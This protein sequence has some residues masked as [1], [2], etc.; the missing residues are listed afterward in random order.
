MAQHRRG[1]VDPSWQRTTR[2][3][4]WACSSPQ[5]PAT[6]F[7]APQPSSATVEATAWGDGADWLLEQVPRLLGA[8]DD[9]PVE[10]ASHP[11]VDQAL[12]AHPHWRLGRMDLVLQALAPSV[13][14]QKVTGQ[15]AFDSWATVVRRHGTPAPGPAGARGLMVPPSNVRLAALPSWEW[16]RASVDHARA[17]ALTQAFARGESLEKAVLAAPERAD[18]LLRTL[19]GIGVWTAAEVRQRA[20]GD[21]D[22]VSYFDYHVAK[23][24]GWAVRGE[25]FTD[26][27]LAEFLRPWEGFRGRVVHLVRRHFGGRPRHGARLEPRRHMPGDR[28]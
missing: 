11:A 2:G 14:E 25:G 13:I 21:A 17:G 19:P 16:L 23:D 6:V 20:L 5:G 8:L 15:E 12:R 28:R 24:V 18:E 1:G 7:I 10:W 4:F 27:E 3:W 9:P 22:A 26:A